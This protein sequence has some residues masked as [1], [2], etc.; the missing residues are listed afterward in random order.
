MKADADAAAEQADLH[1][2]LAG[3]DG[4]GFAAAVL[5]T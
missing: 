5:M 1:V 3:A 2:A 4:I